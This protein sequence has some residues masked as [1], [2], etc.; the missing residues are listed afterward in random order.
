MTET[1]ER[2]GEGL[3]R[4]LFLCEDNF[5]AS[6]FCEEMFNSLVRDE[7]LNWQ[8]TSRSYSPSPA[9]RHL[10]PMSAAAIA[11]LRGAGVAPV[12]HCRLPLEVTP[13]DFETSYIVVAVAPRDQHAAIMRAWPAY[14]SLIE[15]WRRDEEP[16]GQFGEL[17]YSVAS[18][19][20]AMLARSSRRPGSSTPSLS[21]RNGSG[22]LDGALPKYPR[23]SHARS[24]HR[25]INDSAQTHRTR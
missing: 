15:F 14:A 23:L 6:R 5:T 11:A 13:F 10:E 19:L 24:R 17:V 25:L 8:A 16:A 9:R 21:A 4:A 7:G 12:N 2:K 18:M 3:R 1:V 20:D 22:N